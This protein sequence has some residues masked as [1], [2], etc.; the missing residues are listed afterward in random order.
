[1]DLEVDPNEAT[2]AQDLTVDGCVCPQ[3]YRPLKAPSVAD[4]GTNR[5]GVRVRDYNGFC[6]HCRRGCVVVQFKQ[7]G[8]WLIHSFRPLRY[9]S[10]KFVGFEPDWVEVTPLPEPPVVMTGPGGDFVKVP[11]PDYDPAFSAIQGAAGF[12]RQAT[13]AIG[14]LLKIIEKLRHNETDNRK[15]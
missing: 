9:E 4:G 1:M 10:G 5:Y 8:K 2:H 3:C 13:N 12:L 15:H 6:F 11:D 7:D 14:E